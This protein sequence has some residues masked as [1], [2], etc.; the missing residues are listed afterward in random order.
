MVFL[1]C[2]APLLAAKK[3]LYVDSYYP[4]YQWSADITAG[5][6]SI[7]KDHEDIQLKI[8]RM[9]TKR[10]RSEEYKKAIALEARD[11]IYSWKPDVIIASDDNASKY[12]IAPWF[13]NSDIPVVFCGLN[14]DAS[15]YGFPTR[16]ITGMLEVSHANS[17]L[18]TL[19]R[20]ARGNRIGF[21][22]SDTISEHKEVANI[23]KRYGISFN[24]RFVQTFSELKQA[25]LELQQET[26]MIFLQEC[27]S[28]TG[29]NHR[30]MIQ[31]VN[32]NITIPTGTTLNFLSHYVLLTHAKLAGEQGRYAATTALAILDGAS[33]ADIPV[34]SNKKAKIYLNMKIARSLGIKLPMAMLENAHL[35]SAELPRVLYVN[36]YHEGYQ[37][38][39]NIE[40]GLLKALHI[41]TK[42]DGSYDTSNSE[43]EF[44]LLRMDTKLNKSP[45]FI[46]RSVRKA[47]DAID[48]WNPDIVVISDDNAAKYLISPFYKNSGFPVVFCG[49]NWDASIYDFPRENITGMVEID[50]ILET[51]SL[52]R[53]YAKGRR[54]GYIGSANLSNRKSIRNYKK[55]LG[56][57]FQSGKLLM[58]L[59]SWKKE[60]IHLQ[61]EVD[62]LLWLTAGD[63]PGWNPQEIQDFIFANTRIPTGSVADHLA[64]YTLLGTVKIA[65]E[66]GWWAGNTVLRILD[67]TPPAEIKE[68][69]N[70]QSKLYLNM[71]LAKKLGIKFP[72]ELLENATFIDNHVRTTDH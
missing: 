9:D 1:C 53:V 21:L 48:S 6:Q 61:G 50:P 63:L 41:K 28:V 57:K 51:I 54:L 59:D 42:P 27:R 52:L 30:K 26:D 7:L 65:E 2:P 22:A 10:N 55:Q 45:E 31:F 40:K 19:R 37:W 32:E 46:A 71:T 60:Y 56:L 64:D 5:I 15:V 24:I 62:M 43:I 25:F 39:D 20:F 49:L 58:D 36:S 18:R 66:Q 47:R 35:I 44:K 38:S 8:F 67:G 16:N 69:T 23:S 14:W 29:F 68:T 12:L 3:I 34:V 17:M 70:K 72:M 11:L 13:K 33:P 4:N